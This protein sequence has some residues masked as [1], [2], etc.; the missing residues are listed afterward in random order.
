MQAGGDDAHLHI[1]QSST[2]SV[3]LM[4]GAIDEQ[5][6]NI[7]FSYGSWSTSFGLSYAGEPG[8]VQNQDRMDRHT[9]AAVHNRPE[10]T[11]TKVNPQD[12]VWG[13]DVV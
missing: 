1:I 7:M 6:L 2:W 9:S 5:L 12:R 13:W 8:P 11:A 3:P 4:V 10:A